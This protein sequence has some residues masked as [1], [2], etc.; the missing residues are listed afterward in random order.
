M[1]TGLLSNFVVHDLK[2]R[3]APHWGGLRAPDSASTKAQNGRRKSIAVWP[4]AGETRCGLR[5]TAYGGYR[6]YRLGGMRLS[7]VIRL[8]RPAGESAWKG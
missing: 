7:S 1:T 4:G 8:A 3:R 2:G 6:Q 5:R